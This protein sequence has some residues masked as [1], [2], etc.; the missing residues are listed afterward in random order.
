MWAVLSDIH[1]NLEALLA[2]LQD[3]ERFRPSAA[4]CLGDT[5]GYGPNPLE[6]LDLTRRFRVTLR[7]NFEH[8][9]LN[10]SD[11]FGEVAERSVHWTRDELEKPGP[12]RIRRFEFLGSRPWTHQER[13]YLFVH[14][15][16]RNPLHEYV[17]PEDIY[18]PP[19][20]TQIFALFSRYCFNGHTH[21]PGMIVQDG[22]ADRW[23]YVRPEEVE[24]NYRLDDRKTLINVGSVGQP[25]HGDWRASYALLDGDTVRFRRVDYDVNTT[26]KKIHDIPDLDDFLGDRLG[27]G[28]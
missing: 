7:G 2:V 16:P 20:L 23:R 12:D 25:R 17:F 24:F 8:A 22:S 1:A 6:C 13:E 18:C 19:K 26:I 11:G 3:M 5:L 27:E 15:S 4:F 21:I 9:V 10:G 28:R 14:A